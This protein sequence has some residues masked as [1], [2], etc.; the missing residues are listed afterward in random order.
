MTQ[1]LYSTSVDAERKVHSFLAFSSADKQLVI[2]IRIWWIVCSFKANEAERTYPSAS[3]SMV[4]ECVSDWWNLS[5]NFCAIY[6]NYTLFQPYHMVLVRECLQELIGAV[7]EYWETNSIKDNTKLVSFIWIAKSY[8]T[9]R[10]FN[11]YLRWRNLTCVFSIC[12]LCLNR[13]QSNWPSHRN[14]H[15]DLAQSTILPRRRFVFAEILKAQKSRTTS[16][17][18]T[19]ISAPKVQQQLLN[20]G[21]FLQNWQQRRM[22]VRLGS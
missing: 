6:Q 15:M 14:V 1:N 20:S 16:K 8:E 13:E 4:T 7:Y 12:L 5:S 3:C 21:S 17:F 9:L 19:L 22:C 10:K 18:E 2:L 11:L